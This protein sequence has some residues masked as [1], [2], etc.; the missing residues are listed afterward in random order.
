MTSSSAPALATETVTT[1]PGGW[2][3]VWNDRSL[4]GLVVLLLGT[5][6]FD[7][8]YLGRFSARALGIRLAWAALVA[9]M[10]FL[11]DR[12]PAWNRATLYLFVFGSASC[13]VGLAD[14]MGGV[15]TPYFTLAAT[16]PLGV[17][18]AL[19]P[20]QDR[21]AIFLSGAVCC[22]GTLLLVHRAQR[23]VVES[24]FWLLILVCT[25]LVADF[26]GV[27]V[28]RVLDVEQ[29]LRGER[30]RREALEALALSEHRRAQAEKLALVGQLAAGVA[31]EINNPL[32][33]VGSNV[34]YVREE[35]LAPRE[36][37]REALA[38]VLAETRLG[39]RH[40]LQIV[41][42]LKGF[43]R[44]EA[45]EPTDCSLAEVVADAMKLASLR[46]KHVAWLHIDVPVD[47]PRIFVVRQR[48]VQVVIN[49][50]VNAS[51][52]LES[53][54]ANGGEVR[55]TGRLGDA[56][57]VLLVEDNGPGF[58]PQ[59]LPR[60]F[61]PFFTTKGPDKGMGLGLNLSRE[62]VAQ[63]GG[64]LT[65]SNR[66]EGGARLC[67]ELPVGDTA[68]AASFQRPTPSGA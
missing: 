49:L 3:A 43:A 16:M 26:L 7:V 25:T 41:A 56:H 47:L 53:H 62:L 13:M 45:Q 55:V 11:P 17:G 44:M 10:K 36:V 23:P 64:R 59:V 63:F 30:E 6:W 4:G 57:V 2:R 14:T 65:A 34:D 35:L 68:D 15:G 52:V 38:D 5:G 61:E 29:G 32:A 48:L 18:I 28:S 9:V 24:A 67:L 46:L 58:P 42:D 51:D 39:V 50:L 20:W 60:L 54:R 37:D 12:S 21:G 66:P 1:R 8:L 22:A 33:Y 27:R 19:S 40:I 31:H